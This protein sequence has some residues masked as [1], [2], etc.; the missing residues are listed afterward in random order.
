MAPTKRVDDATGAGRDR[1]ARDRLSPVDSDQDRRLTGA[2]LSDMGYELCRRA[3][4]I[5]YFE[6]GIVQIA[7]QLGIARNPG[8]TGFKH[9]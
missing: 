5:R 3:L 6:A 9:P 4:S 8:A 7:A 2:A 1:R